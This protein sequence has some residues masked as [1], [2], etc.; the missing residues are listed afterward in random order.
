RPGAAAPDAPL[1]AGW[2]LDRLG[3]GFVGLWFGRGVEPRDLA[4]VA[5]ELKAS[6]LPAGK[7][8]PVESDTAC[9]RYGAEHRPAFYLV[10]PDGHVAARW[11]TVRS[12]DVGGAL[13]LASGRSAPGQA[14]T[15][16]GA[17]WP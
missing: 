17:P 1:G 12:G 16:V 9:R 13:A 10:R 4:M 7:V 6:G 5:A 15:V 11:R 14:G 8:A 2:L 3:R